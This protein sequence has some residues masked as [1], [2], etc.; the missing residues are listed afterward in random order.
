M[1]SSSNGL[2]LERIDNNKDY[3]PEN[4]KWITQSEQNKN[5][6]PFSEWKKH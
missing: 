6:R 5:R 4:C 1:G 3:S 2:T